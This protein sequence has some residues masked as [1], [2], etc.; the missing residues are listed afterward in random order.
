[1]DKPDANP[2]KVKQDLTQY[3]LVCEDWG[4]ETICVPVS[5]TCTGR[6]MRTARP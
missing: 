6:P 4:G 5:G 1:M 3:G 2:E